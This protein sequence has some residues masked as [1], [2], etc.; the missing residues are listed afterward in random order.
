MGTS[1]VDLQAILRPRK[2]GLL[3]NRFSIAEIGAQQLTAEVLRDPHIMAAYAEAFGVSPRSFGAAPSKSQEPG[4]ERQWADAPYTKDFWD[5][6]GC[7]YVAIDYDKSPHIIPLDLNF[8]D[9]PEQH[10][11]K[12]DLVTNSGTTEHVVNQLQAMKIIHDLPA[13]G[14]LMIHTVPTQGNADHA[15]F[16]YNPKFFFTLSRSCRYHINEMRFLFAAEGVPIP[17]NIV[18]F[19][20][21]CEPERRPILN[22]HRVADTYLLVIMQKREDIPFVP[23]IEIHGGVIDDPIVSSRYWTILGND[24]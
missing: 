6:L 9:V 4:V 14:G 1:L 7:P 5:W 18:E 2:A 22:A 10:K 23:P 13:P 21:R 11:G 19:V 16:N 24:K 17:Q 12:Y 15:M 8:D 20:T 3:S